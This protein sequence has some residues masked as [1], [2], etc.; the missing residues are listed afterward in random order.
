MKTIKKSEMMADLNQ[1]LDQV[2][3]STLEKA[4]F[5]P[6]ENSK[7]N[8]YRVENGLVYGVHFPIHGTV[9][10]FIYL[11]TGISVVPLFVWNEIPLQMP[12]QDNPWC[13]STD[14]FLGILTTNRR[15]L[16]LIEQKTGPLKQQ[17][18]VTPAAIIGLPCGRRLH[19]HNTERRGAEVL[20]DIALP[21]LASIKSVE[22]IYRFNLEI[23][24]VN[25]GF[26]TM[27]QYYEYI[28]KKKQEGKIRYD[29]STALADE[30]VALRDEKMYPFFLDSLEICHAEYMKGLEPDAPWAKKNRKF[31]LLE[32][33]H[34]ALL[35]HVMKEK[36]YA[37]WEEHA[38]QERVKMLQQIRKKLPGLPIDA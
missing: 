15:Y 30:G 2:Y 17:S 6:L 32:S 22:D 21:L 19:V 26:D 13:A 31:C 18:Y 20:E 38:A 35:I 37:L 24:R 4:G 1:Y 14:R 33:E 25:K 27:D 8:W 11:N 5:V 29:F 34:S 28:R 9:N 23:R 12:I 16:D 3:S 7:F 36:D 10:P